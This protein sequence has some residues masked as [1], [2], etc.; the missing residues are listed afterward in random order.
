MGGRFLLINLIAN[1]NSLSII[2]YLL[3]MNFVVGNYNVSYEFTQGIVKPI[4]LFIFIF[5]IYLFFFVIFTDNL[6]KR[7]FRYIAWWYFILMFWWSFSTPI[8]TGIIT[9]DRNQVR[10]VFDDSTKYNHHSICLV[11]IQATADK[12]IKSGGYA[13]V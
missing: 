7:W 12:V 9:F 3:Y 2:S 6:F 5:T 10:N 1:F 8:H 11:G 13:I 4:I